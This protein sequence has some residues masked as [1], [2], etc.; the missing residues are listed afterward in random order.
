MTDY[1]V[2]VK[3]VS[4]KLAEYK[5]TTPQILVSDLALRISTDQY[6][7]S[8]AT[9][10][11][12][13]ICDGKVLKN[14]DVIIAD[15]N[16]VVILMISKV[17][18][19]KQEP[20]PIEEKVAPNPFNTPVEVELDEEAVAHMIVSQYMV[21]RINP[22]ITQYLKP[23]ENLMELV[24]KHSKE[25]GAFS[26]GLSQLEDEPLAI[27]L[28]LVN[29]FKNNGKELFAQLRPI[30]KM[31]AERVKT[32]GASGLII[33]KNRTETELDYSKL[34]EQQLLEV[35]SAVIEGQPELI[36]EL[37]SM[38]TEQFRQIMISQ[39][40][41]KKLKKQLD[42]LEKTNPQAFSQ[43]LQIKMME[44][45]SSNQSSELN[46]EDLKKIEEIS[47]NF[48][49]S[50]EQVKAVYIQCGKNIETTVNSLYE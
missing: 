42:D 26:E 1:I 38:D 47:I 40:Q 3:T 50:V 36:E 21:C 29:Y 37:S 41:V 49:F 14:T 48:G 20:T 39:S 33:D 13:L 7:D 10:L 2:K 27:N 18:T 30:C 8:P 12:R 16:T 35:K 5:F 23:E 44:T 34:T 24:L 46:S 15:I 17:A 19:K 32:D 25:S 11:Q 45:I 6:F 43:A 4:G 31:L 9:E 28:I 22:V